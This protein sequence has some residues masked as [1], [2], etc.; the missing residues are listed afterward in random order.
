MLS[1]NT[2]SKYERR[3]PERE[4][5]MKDPRYPVMINLAFGICIV[6]S[7]EE[8]ARVL[9]FAAWAFGLGGTAILI[10]LLVLGWVTIDRIAHG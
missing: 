2:F 9:R 6:N 7:P 10:E 5:G 8:E 1:A 4:A 3:R